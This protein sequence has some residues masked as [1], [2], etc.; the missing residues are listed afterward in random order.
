MQM[1]ETNERSR[2][3][4]VSLEFGRNLFVDRVFFVIRI[5]M[6]SMV[7]RIVILAFVALLPACASMRNAGVK[8]TSKTFT[9]VV[10]DA[11]HGGKD[12]GAY[13]RYGPPE[14]MVALDVA[15]RLNRNLR[16]SQLKTLMT[17]SS[18]VFIP[19]DDRVTIENSQK[20]AIFVSIH[21]NDSRQRGIHGFETYYHSGV[22]SDLANRIQEKLMTIPH[23]ANRG[24]HTANFRVLRNATCPAVLVECGFLSNRAE[25]GQARDS[26]Y[27]QLLADR[28]AEAVVE[29]R[30]GPGVYRGSPQLAAQSQQAESSSGGAG[31]APAAPRR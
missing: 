10:V 7:N 4:T 6:S 26:E 16:E 11:G 12:S 9:T 27:R 13:R 22:S 18:D 19:L 8:N 28:I 30:Y 25:G 31:L 15:Q 29:Q 24:V 1:G 20:N 2:N 23:S 17:R 5:R 21:F 3:A 14:K